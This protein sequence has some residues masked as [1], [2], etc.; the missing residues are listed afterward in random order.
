M[1]E[2]LFAL[3][4][5]IRQHRE[6]PLGMERAAYLQRLADL[7]YQ[8]STLLRRAAY[9]LCVARELV[10]WP[11]AY[12][13]TPAE[14]DAMGAEWARDRPRATASDY[15][16][17]HFC[18]HATEFLEFLGRLI[19]EPPRPADP[20]GQELDEFIG[21]Q[22][23]ERGLSESTCRGRRSKLKQFL[24]YI[25]DEG[26]A[27]GD[28][29]PRHIDGFFKFLSQRWS[30][31]SLQCMTSPLRAWF[32]FAQSR[33]WVTRG[34]AEAVE[35]P[36]IYQEEGLPLGPTWEDAQRLLVD[37][38]TDR[39][40]DLRDRAILLLILVYGFRSGEVRR[41]SLDDIDWEEDRIRFRRGKS[42]R[43]QAFP[44]EPIVGNALARYLRE[45]RPKIDSRV[46]FLTVRAPFRP[47]SRAG[48]YNVVRPRLD[49]LGWSGK[50]RGPH[51]LRHA[52]ARK[53]VD[54]DLSLKV[55]G[56]HLGHS[57]SKSTRIYTKVDL[58]SLR[59][60]AFED[61]GGL[62]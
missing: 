18:F 12:R 41:L 7:G 51:G 31:R 42:Y 62:R 46:V 38:E 44:I 4:G 9:V 33:G 40:K 16:K 28:V 15:P 61:L 20:Y 47:L 3:K 29:S 5:V 49:Q 6:G 36:R 57:S 53:L 23:E 58:T 30:R 2:V 22:R 56:D 55:V 37:A 17:E 34:L 60:V 59:R 21:W 26:I 24:I 52:C 1:F 50:G 39:P 43:L 48:V 8:Q 27:L 32:R 14:V 10:K 19:P 35:S 45:G 25:E 13:F 54:S 11:A